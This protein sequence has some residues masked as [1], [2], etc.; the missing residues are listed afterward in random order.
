LVF[1]E[2]LF[3]FPP[4]MPTQGGKALHFT[5]SLHCE[6]E[7]MINWA[8]AIISELKVFILAR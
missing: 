5:A 3:I 6:I 4:A 2:N 1:D 8:L 7:K